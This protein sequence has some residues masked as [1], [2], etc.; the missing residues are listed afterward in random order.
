VSIAVIASPVTATVATEYKTASVATG[1]KRRRFPVIV[2]SLD[3]EEKK[4]Q[5]TK[6]TEQQSNCY[7]FPAAFQRKQ[8]H[9]LLSRKFHR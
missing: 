9:W 2:F 6:Y 8:R 1:R 5:P 3:F 4:I 7:R